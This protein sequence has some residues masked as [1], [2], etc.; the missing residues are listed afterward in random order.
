MLRNNH[1]R[2]GSRIPC[3][4]GCRPSGG[5][6]HTILS[7][8]PEN[9]MK[10]RKFWAM[11][12]PLHHGPRLTKYDQCFGG[13]STSRAEPTRSPDKHVLMCILYKILKTHLASQKQML[14]MHSTHFKTVRKT[15]QKTLRPVHTERKLTRKRKRSKNNLK[16]SKKLSDKHQSKFLFSRS[17]SLGVGRPLRV[18]QA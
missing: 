12:P 6:Q 14:G 9:C 18:N 7:N 1:H 2:G 3:R 11:D 17:L 13:N 5:R 10:L 15:V 16:S 8:F 4:R